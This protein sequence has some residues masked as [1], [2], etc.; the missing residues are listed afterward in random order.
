MKLLRNSGYQQIHCQHKANTK[1]K[2]KILKR[3]CEAS[4]TDKKRAQGTENPDDEIN[5]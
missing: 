3:V 5:V 1:N 4:Y 2:E